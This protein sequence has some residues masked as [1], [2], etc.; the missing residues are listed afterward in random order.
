MGHTCTPYA[1]PADELLVTKAWHAAVRVLPD[2]G[3][4]GQWRFIHDVMSGTRRRRFSTREAAMHA[5]EV[6]AEA[7]RKEARP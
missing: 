6:Y 5:A 4:P 7:L 3:A 1:L 2:G